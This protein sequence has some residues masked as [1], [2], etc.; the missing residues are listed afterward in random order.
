MLAATD[1]PFIAYH[2]GHSHMYPNARYPGMETTRKVWLRELGY[3]NPPEI[4]S[5]PDIIQ[6][7]S[8]EKNTSLKNSRFVRS[9]YR[10]GKDIE[11][12]EFYFL[13]AVGMGYR[14]PNPNRPPE[15]LWEPFGKT[16]QDIDFAD[17]S[18]NFF[19][20]HTKPEVKNRKFSIL[21]FFWNL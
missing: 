5:F 11:S 8:Y 20:K 10:K 9:C 3:L 4:D 12:Q 6:G 15:K 16:N 19:K 17:L 13:K 2:A 21:Y 1:D 14:W 7:E 18:L